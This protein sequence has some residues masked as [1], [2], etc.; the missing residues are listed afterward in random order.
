MSDRDELLR[1]LRTRAFEEREV[2]L[3]SGKKSSFYIDCKQVTLLAEGHVLVGRLL[4]AEI[5]RWEAA[6][7][8]RLW[9]VGG[10]TLGADPIASAVSMTSALQNAPI[11]AFIV[12]KE[13]KKHGTEQYLEGI[14]NIP[15]WARMLLPAFE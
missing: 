10:L 4:L 13:P 1:L 8:R 5:R 12:R 15:R 7:G 11:P 3:A 6:K 2:T 14:A 9:A